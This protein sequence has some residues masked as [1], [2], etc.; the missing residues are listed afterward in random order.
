LMVKHMDAINALRL[1]SIA[2]ERR[3]IIGALGHRVI[4]Q[5]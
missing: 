3:D 1:P 2:G 5:V 4:G